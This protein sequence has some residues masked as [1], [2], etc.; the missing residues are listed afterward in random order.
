MLP[1]MVRRIFALIPVAAGVLVT[2]SLLIHLVPGDPVDTILGEYATAE[3]K[4]ALREQMGLNRPVAIQIIG[5]ATGVLRGDLGQSLIFSKPVSDLISSRAEATAELA[6]I[7][8]LLALAISVPL[9]VLSALR[10]DTAWD[11]TSMG[12]AL[13]GVAIP[14]FWLGPLLVLLFSVHL[15]WLPV[16]E[17]ADLSSYI[18]PAITMGT[19]LAAILSRMIRTSMLEN[20]QEDFVRTAVSKGLGPAVVVGKHV[21]RNAA[22]PVVTIVGLQFGVLLTG[23]V[24]TEKIFDWPGLGLLMLEGI[25]NRDYPVVQGCVLVFSCSYLLVNLATDLVYAA[26]DPRIKLG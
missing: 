3:E 24:I 19:A 23:A 22:I 4:S 12:V 8:L 9:G 6:L 11:Y 20:L 2:V 10:K 1:Y 26:I 25:N 16:S 7:S 17:R 15:G 5:Y 13:L 21:S 14:N 18:L